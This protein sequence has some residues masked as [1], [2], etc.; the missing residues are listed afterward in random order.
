MNSRTSQFED[1]LFYALLALLVWLPLPMGSNRPWAEAILELGTA[2]L[3]LLWIMGRQRSRVTVGHAFNGAHPVLWLLA[4][5][6]VYLSAQLIPL[7]ATVRQLISPESVAMYRLA[8]NAGWAPLSL[9]PYATFL[10]WLKSVAYVSLFVLTLLMVNCKHRLVMLGYAL[11]FS[12]VLQAFYGSMMALSGLEYGFFMK[13]V[14][15]V[16]FATGTF[17]NRNHLAGYLEMVSA[18]GI[19]L[20]MATGSFMEGGRSWRQRLRNLINLVLSQK[21]LLRLML[22]IMVIALVLTR[23]RMGNTGFF[24]SML[25]AGLIALVAFRSQVSSTAQMFQR[26]EMRSAVVLITSL[27]VIDLFIVGAWFGVDK[28]ADRMVQ[29]SLEHD[30][31]RVEVGSNTLDLLKDYPLLG[32]GGGS[33]HVVYER[34]RGE[35][36]SEHYDHAHQDYLEIMADV[37]AIGIVLLGLVV[38]LSFRAAL[39]ALY[40]RRDRL[41]RGM[42]FASIMGTIALLIHSTVDFNLQIPANAA[43]FMVVLALGWIA[44]NLER[45]QKDDPAGY[46]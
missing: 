16:G 20:L 40:C 42:A 6:L 7:P 17:V 25:V 8:G 33:F 4:A 39:K 11:V 38:L 35:G 32:A 26:S 36:I 1:R 37:G 24:S 46:R 15:Y 3:S 19:G 10:F 13:K 9:H 29:T 22:A 12:A 31:G 18:I 45:Q 27:M 14:S 28:L 21:L 34:Y 44:L 23:S 5:W 43:T 2:G 41:M 30:A